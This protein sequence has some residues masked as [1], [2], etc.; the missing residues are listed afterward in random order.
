MRYLFV[1]V[2]LVSA[3]LAACGPTPPE[4]VRPGGGKAVVQLGEACG[5]DG[6]QTIGCV[7]ESAAACVDGAFQTQLLEISKIPG[8]FYSCGGRCSYDPTQSAMV[9]TGQSTGMRYAVTGESCSPPA[10]RALDA[11]RAAVVIECSDA[12]VWAPRCA[13]AGFSGTDAGGIDCV[14]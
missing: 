5:G 7:G 10:P 11:W 12:G 1:A 13:D 6:G 9:C 3:V 14:P 8:H 4:P 2:V